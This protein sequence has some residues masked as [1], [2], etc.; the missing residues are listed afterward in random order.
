MYWLLGIIVLPGL[1][2]GAIAQAKVHSTYKKMSQVPTRRGATANQI[3]REVLDNNDLSNIVL[4]TTP[5]T[6]GDHYDP[7]GE[8]IA[9]SPGVH[10]QSS[11]ASVG[12]AMH[13]VGHALQDK[14]GY[15]FSKLRKFLVPVINFC[16]TALWPLI[17]I[18]LIFNF[19]AASDSIVGDIFMWAGVIFFGMSI[20]FSLVT[21]PTEIDASRRALRVLRDNQY[22]E[23]DELAGVKKV[24]TAAALTY[25][26][27]L[28]VAI[29]NFARFLITILLVRNNE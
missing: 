28:L 19:A 7:K 26:A 23:E 4:T 6:L 2:L 12:I 15:A 24:L 20:I 5:E 21:L 8:V 1:I 18:G 16:S 13:E 11:I 17:I 9:L 3:A 22:L 14:E 27:A 25:V 29:L 10:E